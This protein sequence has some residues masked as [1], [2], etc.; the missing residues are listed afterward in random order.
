MKD[1][2]H[3]EFDDD[4]YNYYPQEGY[5]DFFKEFGKM[6]PEEM[7]KKWNDW[8]EDVL[9]ELLVPITV[10]VLTR[11]SYISLSAKP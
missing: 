10:I 5:D 11:Y 7:N 2:E 8:I 9:D 6:T 4:E 3:N 1:P